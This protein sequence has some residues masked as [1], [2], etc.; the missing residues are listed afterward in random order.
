[1]VGRLHKLERLGLAEPLGPARWRLS[2]RAEPTL[3]A[4]GERDDII[5]RIHR[6]LAEQR[7]DLSVGEFDSPNAGS[8]GIPW[9]RSRDEL[10]ETAMC[11]CGW[12]THVAPGR[13][14]SLLGGSAARAR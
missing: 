12:R 2:E 7:I 11:H 8:L 10:K 1:M 13:R 9:H 3:R 14:L 4:L 6:G 5:K